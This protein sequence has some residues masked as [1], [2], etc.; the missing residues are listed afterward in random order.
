[1]ELL[2]G[3]RV[4][5]QLGKLALVPAA[6]D[7]LANVSELEKPVLLIHGE[8]DRITPAAWAL[9]IFQHARGPCF[10]WVAE[11]AGHAPAP[12]GAFYEL[13]HRRVVAFLDRFV[14]GERVGAFYRAVCE[15]I[16]DDRVRVR[17]SPVAAAAGR[18]PV[19]ACVATRTSEGVG[20]ARFR[21][22]S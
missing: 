16:D 10:L 5:A 3:S 15:P 21:G 12:A 8:R 19:E 4:L 20:F 17:V 6:L 14:L 18:V 7:A 11:G 22:F 9:E 1:L 13:Y 2:T